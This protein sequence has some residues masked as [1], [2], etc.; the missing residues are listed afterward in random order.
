MMYPE[1]LLHPEVKLLV[2][3]FCSL[4]LTLTQCPSIQQPALVTKQSEA[5]L[6]DVGYVH[7]RLVLSI[8]TASASLNLIG[9]KFTSGCILA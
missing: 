8:P 9:S 5:I 3:G 1:A 7:W 6:L 2:E 4:L